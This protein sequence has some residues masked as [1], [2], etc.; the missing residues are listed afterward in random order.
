MAHFVTS[1]RPFCVSTAQD[2]RHSSK[3]I[4]ERNLQKMAV[5]SFRVKGHAYVI[6]HV[7]EATAHIRK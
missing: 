5:N 2:R 6:S 3:V 7:V 1:R 4:L